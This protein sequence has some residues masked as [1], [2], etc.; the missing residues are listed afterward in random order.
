MGTTSA[1][2]VLAER[3]NQEYAY[4]VWWLIAPFLFL[5]GLVHYGSVVLRVITS[6]KKSADVE[7]DGQVVRHRASVRRLPLAITNVYRVL[8]FRTTFTIGPFSLNLAE[9]ALTIAYIVALFVWSFINTTSLNGTK[10]A[11]Q[12]YNNRV[13]NIACGQLP[14]VVA[15]GTKNNIVG[16]ITGLSHEKINYMHRM[17]ARVVF[18]LLSV[19][20]GVRLKFLKSGSLQTQFIQVGILAISSFGSLIIV[21]LRPVRKAAYELFFFLHFI[22]VLIF[23][24]GGYI[25]TKD[26]GVAYWFWVSFIIWGLDRFIR[27]VRLTA[28]NYSYFGFKRGTGTMDADIELLSPHLVRLRLFRPPHFHWSPGQAAYLIMPGVSTIPFE[29]HP[30][31][32][33]SVDTTDD[34]PQWKATPTTEEKEALAETKPYWKE[35]VFLINVHSGFTRKLRDVSEKGSKL[36]V[37]VD[38]PYGKSPDLT[39]YDTSV[40]IAGGSGVSFTLPLFLDGIK[41]AAAGNSN[42]KR[43]VF[44][45]SIRDRSHIAWISE[46]LGAATKLAP[47]G[48][49]VSV[50][51]FI[52]GEDVPQQSDDVS[53]K[54][55]K[56]TYGTEGK[57]PPPSLFEDPAVQITSGSRANLKYILQKE[58]DLTC[59]RMGVTVCGSQ[60][61]TA[62]VKNALG[63]SIAGPSTIMKGGPSITLHTE[64]FGYA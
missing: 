47:A 10:F 9:V 17:T 62:T 25:H 31:T 8:A 15:L 53:V 51:I 35:L 11:R 29:A 5:V 4:Q 60:S 49:D 22:M 33:A 32:I 36:K 24:V 43:I 19:H 54:S 14:L 20:A 42:A 61:I 23:L 46:T 26:P 13:A 30:F 3:Y 28:F 7:V 34:E 58:A 16:M 21:S 18:V 41:N 27:L 45:W 40:L 63:F 12:Y 52:T 57:S 6:K 48:L 1:D 2:A 55:G 38:G 37:F 59:G 56:E 50:R 44:I 39:K 64:A